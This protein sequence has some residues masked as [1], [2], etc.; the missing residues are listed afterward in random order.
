MELAARAVNADQL[1]ASAAN[2]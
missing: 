1:R 2:S